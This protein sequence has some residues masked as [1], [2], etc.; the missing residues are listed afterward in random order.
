MIRGVSSAPMYGAMPSGMD[1]LKIRADM[2]YAQFCSLSHILTTAEIENEI[3]NNGYFKKVTLAGAYDD[4]IATRWLNNSWSTERMLIQNHD[5]LNTTDQAFCMQWAFPQA[6]YAVFGSLLAMYQAIGYTETS[7]TGVMKKFGTLAQKGQI[8]ESLS[9]CCDGTKKTLT[10]TNLNDPDTTDSTLRFDPNDPDSRC[11]HICQF[12]KSTRKLKL[13]KAKESTKFFN[14]KGKRLKNLKPDHW[15]K[16]SDSIG[17]TTCIDLLYRK[18]IKGN[19]QDI[20]TYSSPH[21]KGKE[22]LDFLVNIVDRINL[23]TEAY[24]AKAISFDSYEAKVNNFLDSVENQ[25][26][27]DRL[28]IIRAID[29]AT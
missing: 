11:K 7:H 9:I 10:I 5:I 12:L 25:K 14:D 2:N 26:L 3:I 16:L 28:E 29:Q 15:Q 13:D 18:R 8:P 22:V 21:F 20:E 6:Y 1:E 19:Y 4:A 17:V 24:C 23:M 27:R